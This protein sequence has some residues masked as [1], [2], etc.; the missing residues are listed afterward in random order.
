MID[1]MARRMTSPV[2]VGRSEVLGQL[3]AAFEAARRGEPRHVVVGGEAGVGKT[4]LLSEGR[5]SA[6]AAGATVLVGGCVSMGDE[7]LPFAPYIEILRSLIARDGAAK[8]AATAGR[9]S[10]D[11]ARLVPALASGD[12]AP[13]QELWAQTRLYEAL[14]ELFRRCSDDAPLVLQL[15]DLHWADA[16]TLAATSLLLRAIE[17]EPISIVATFRTDEITRR[18]PLRPWL[19][20][21]SRL[22]VIERL[23]L[24][25]LSGPEIAQLVGHILDEELSTAEVDDIELRSDGN[26][27]F[28]EELLASRIVGR[29]T[30]P[31]ELRDVLL[32]RIDVLPESAQHLLGVAA[33]GGRVVE[34]ETLIEVV[35]EGQDPAAQDLRQLVD[36]GLLIPMRA[37]DDDDAYGFRHALLQEAVYEAMLPTERRRLHQA[38]GETLAAHEAAA[39]SGAAYRLQLAHHWREARDTRALSAT[40]AAGDAAVDAFSFGTALREYEEALALWDD[41]DDAGDGN[42]GS[43]GIDHVELLERTARAAYLS[44]HFRRAIA[45]SREAIDELGDRSAARLTGVLILLAR[46][47]WVDGDWGASIRVY[48]QAVE[49]APEDPPIV[50]LQARAGLAQVYMLHARMHEARPLCETTIAAAQAIGARELEGHGRNTL[51]VVLAGLGETEAAEASIAAALDIALELGIP[52]DIGR[53]YVNRADIEG[54]AGDPERALGTCLEGLQVTAEWGVANSYGTYLGYGAVSFGF[55]AGAWNEAREALARAD[56]QAGPSGGTSV[57]RSTYVLEFMACSRR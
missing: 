32:S 31:W 2:L 21:V 12:A 23:D 39:V 34:H 55:E 8:V 35:G 52:D 56:R 11:L 15:E 49:S 24:E 22:S 53:A 18:H 47:L 51:A 46:T 41:P 13:S 20:E 40:V 1:A 50:R 27:F 17:H 44:S 57:Y 42:H 29:E 38:W 5:A 10:G 26:P 3:E 43:D 28:I 19:A 4:R 54:W 36:A 25:P 14:L 33:V 7:G 45:A 16:G 30:L 48:E 9:A 6:E 37:L